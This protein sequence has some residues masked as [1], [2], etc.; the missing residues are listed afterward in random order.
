MRFNFVFPF[1]VVT[2]IA[3]SLKEPSQVTWQSIEQGLQSKLITINPGDTL[4]LPE[5]NF[6]FTRSL[7]MNGKSNIL[8][9]GK[10]MDTFPST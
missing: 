9:R 3:C 5:G 2:V 8:I 4:D 10:G 7:D 6:M 1:L